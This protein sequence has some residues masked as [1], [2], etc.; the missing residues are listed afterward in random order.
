MSYWRFVR[1]ILICFIQSLGWLLTI[2]PPFILYYLCVFISKY[3]NLELNHLLLVGFGAIQIFIF[4]Y[5]LK[6]DYEKQ[7]VRDAKELTEAKALFEKEMKD[8]RNALEMKEIDMD[9]RMKEREAKVNNLKNATIKLLESKTPFKE[10]AK[11]VSDTVNIEFDEAIKALRHKRNPALRAADQI[12]VFKN[13]T[14]EALLESKNLTYKIDYICSIFPEIADYLND[15]QDLIDLSQCPAYSELEEQRDRTKDFLS[16]Q[17]YASLS[18]T[19][20]NQLALDR[21]L[22]RTKTPAQIGRDYEMSC[23]FKLRSIGYEVEEHGIKNGV[24]DMGRDLI[25]SRHIANGDLQCLIIQCKCWKHDRP[26]RE[27]VVFQLYGTYISFILENGLN[28]D[29]YSEKIRI[30]PILMI[31][32]FSKVSDVAQEICRRLNIIIRRQDHIEYP[33]I[34]CNVNK[35]QK[36]YHLP[37]DQLYNLTEIKNKE[38]F[39]AYTV[40]EAE[41]KGF[42][43]A[44]RHSW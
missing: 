29:N 32:S 40:K 43:R 25:A 3:F 8:R 14:R 34:K 10:C 36:I 35:G 44:M 20:R 27:N 11:M 4:I 1:C 12:K 30:Y 37:F 28:S 13:K 18:V 7:K 38:E 2:V 26:I 5:L 31:P 42:R 33:R 17:E 21:Y 6:N 41:S 39:Y 19:E 24:H 22:K 9:T 16:P 15:E 23:S